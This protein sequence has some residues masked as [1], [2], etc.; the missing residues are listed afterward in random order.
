MVD[1]QFDVYIANLR[2]KQ[3]FLLCVILF[4]FSAPVFSQR[5]D[6][7]EIKNKVALNLY[8]QAIE[9]PD[10]KQKET[11]ILLKEAVKIA[12][13]F[14]DA[15][16]KLGE[17]NYQLALKTSK[18]N[19]RRKVYFKEAEEYFLK[20]NS[21]CPS[22]NYYV[23]SYYLGDYYY[24]QR[25]F[26]KSGFFLHQFLD[27]NKENSKL[28]NKAR[29]MVKNVDYYLELINNPVPFNPKPLADI[30]TDRDEYLPLISP[31]EELMIFSRRTIRFANTA[32][33]KSEEKLNLSIRLWEDSS[34]FV[35]SRGRPMEAPFNDGRNQGGATITI[36]NNHIFITI[37]EFE[38]ADYTSYKNCDIFSSD[39]KNGKWTALKRLG[40]NV[41]SISTFEGMPSITA[42]GKTLYF[43]SA[44]EGG[45]GGLDIYKTVLDENG[46]WGK[47]QN[48]GPV[49][50]TAGDEKTPFIHSDSQTLYFST[51]GIFGL[52]G[53]D[54]FYSQY[55]GH[56]QWTGPKN[57]GYPI[58][59]EN[60]ELGLMVSA[61]GKNIFF[62]SR[63]LNETGDWDIYIAT[64]Y[65]KAR[66]QRV[67]FVKGK[68]YDEEGKTIKKAKVELVNITTDELT[69]GFVDD[70][71]GNYAVAVPV[72]KGDEFI[73]T[74]KKKG[75]FFNSIYI[76]PEDEKYDPPTTVDFKVQK[77]DKNKR[78]ILKNV[79][80]KTGSDRLNELS[81]SVLDVLVDFLKENH[82]VKI[83]LLGYTDNMGETDYNLD[84]SLRRTK[85]VKK[86]LV[87]KGINSNRISAHGYGEKRPIAS[88][89]TSYGRSLNRRVEFIIK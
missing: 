34:G 14:A 71:S 81:K 66:P 82:D 53:F 38:R 61:N 60:D 42:D 13:D 87:S 65:E 52:G 35:F 78:I 55:L 69:E 21:L 54:I 8:K 26:E 28:V 29:K 49:I 32:H 79:N 7:K 25:K 6:C 67:L 86:Y 30:C 16:Y 47:A 31:D 57:L 45:Y 12:P 85:S 83:T 56:G 88:N 37:C 36:D 62:S 5:G 4:V 80:F 70:N 20:V 84:L 27:N 3:Y 68:L 41:N 44:R 10:Y 64:L 33:E 50:N 39:R 89:T 1:K 63:A 15:Y 51:N 76:N 19:Q 58:N 59:T 75:F 73:M 17:I 2:K 11:Q 46:N 72:N 24:Q 48:L 77:I 74:A 40:A 23:S 18:D 22:F 9:N 43:S